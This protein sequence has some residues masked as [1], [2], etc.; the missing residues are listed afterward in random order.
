MP[1]PTASVGGGG[2]PV[3]SRESGETPPPAT[4]PDRV[5]EVQTHVAETVRQPPPIEFVHCGAVHYV[6]IRPLPRGAPIDPGA[7]AMVCGGCPVP[8][9][10]LR[11]TCHCCHRP[12]EAREAGGR[13]LRADA[14]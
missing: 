12:L 10:G 3:K 7:V 6:S 13:Q 5:F 9:R 2:T 1:K 4:L 14:G 8:R 11:L